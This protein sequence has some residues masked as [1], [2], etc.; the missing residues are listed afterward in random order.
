MAHLICALSESS[1]VN[2]S[3]RPPFYTRSVLPGDM[4]AAEMPQILIVTGDTGESYEALYAV[5]R[6][7]EEGWRVTVAALRFVASTSSC[8][9]L[10][11]GGIPMSNVPDT[12]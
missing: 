8:T 5:H 6:F 4:M 10:S 2:V 7:R 1:T 12:V 3:L 9:T 11:R